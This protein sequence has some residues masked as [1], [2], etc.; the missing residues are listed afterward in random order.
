MTRVP[1]PVFPADMPARQRLREFVRTLVNRLVVDHEPA[2]HGQLIMREMLIPTKACA[3][4]VT[5]YVRPT[6]GVLR[7]I[8]R[9]LLPEVSDRQRML[10]GFSIVGQVFHYRAARPV[11]TLLMGPEAFQTLDVEALT[12][13]ITTFSLS[14]IDNIVKQTSR[15]A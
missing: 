8:L 2:W 1:M 15:G 7:E 12:D 3:E 9:E 11:I 4:F 14:A 6:F 10:V 13:H 5:D